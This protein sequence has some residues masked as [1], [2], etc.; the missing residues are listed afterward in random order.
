MIMRGY[1]LKGR[2]ELEFSA[3]L[4]KPVPGY[5]EVLV[6]V[7]A[8]TV[9]N[10]SDVVYFNY[11]GLRKHCAEGCFGH[12]I[13]GVVSNVGAGVERFRA[14]DRVFVRTPLTTGYAEYALARE[15][16]IG[17]LPDQ[18]PFSEGA[19]LQLLPLAIHATRGVNLGDRVVIVGQGPV[20]LMALQ[21]AKLR[22]ASTVITSD[23]DPWRLD[24]SKTL[25]ADVTCAGGTAELKELISREFRNEVDVAIDAV[26]TPLTAQTCIDL[27]RHNGL[28]ILLGT[29]HVDTNV[30]FD[31]IQWEK[32]GL[33]IHTAAEPTDIARVAAMQIAERLTYSG[34]I[35]T[36][37]LLTHTFALEQ[38]PQAIQHL[39]QSS[40]LFSENEQSPYAGPP[41]R[42]LKV[43]ICP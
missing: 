10:R 31:L 37:I 25:E 20:G 12:E 19:I 7:G 34:V 26:G 35:R 3:E 32:K 27:L 4:P 5:A 28:L 8:C 24:I 15:I 11:F 30:T 40:I 2:H 41:P 36:D 22:G 18:I 6:Q 13:A 1:V 33:R 16:S 38:L 29:H 17:R 42:T 39:S 23:L 21:I 43:G 9:C 14:G